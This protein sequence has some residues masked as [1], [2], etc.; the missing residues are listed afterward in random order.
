MAQTTAIQ[1]NAIDAHVGRRITALRDERSM[2]L[3][4]VAT[5]L[6]LQT[7]VLAKMEAGRHRI[8]AALIQK[9]AI[10]LDVSISDL[11]SGATIAD[12]ALEPNRSIEHTW[13]SPEFVRLARCFVEIDDPEKREAIVNLVEKMSVRPNM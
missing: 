3:E 13:F 12:E 4:T 7:D 8:G 1:A 2:S 5:E 10:V 6:G 9:A 11:F